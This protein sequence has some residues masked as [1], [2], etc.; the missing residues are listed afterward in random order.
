LIPV[1]SDVTAGEV[2]EA[3][4]RVRELHE[5]LLGLAGSVLP[6]TEHGLELAAA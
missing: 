4:D 5:E 2:V 3:P 1:L 6:M